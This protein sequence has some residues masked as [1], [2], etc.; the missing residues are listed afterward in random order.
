MSNGVHPLL[1]R[2]LKRLGLCPDRVPTETASWQELLVRVGRAYEELEQER[3]LLDRSQSLVAVE[4][5]ALYATVRADRDQL[6]SR[7]QER[8]EAL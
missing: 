8:T 5:A 3:Y 6:E 2:Q 1:R 7:V 4:M